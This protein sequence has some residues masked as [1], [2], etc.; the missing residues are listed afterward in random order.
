MFFKPISIYSNQIFS[1]FGSNIEKTHM[2]THT[3]T[4]QIIR[5]LKDIWNVSSK[6]TYLTF[7]LT[8]LIMK[9]HSEDNVL[10]SFDWSILIIFNNLVNSYISHKWSCKFCYILNY[11]SPFKQIVHKNVQFLWF[12]CFCFCLF[13]S[14]SSF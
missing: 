10:T 2:H 5:I 12:F 13:L 3:H 7:Q 4:Q 11:A 9:Q 1:T 6:I 8:N 14:L